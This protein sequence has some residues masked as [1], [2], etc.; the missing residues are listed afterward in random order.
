M[1]WEDL[2][3]EQALLAM[4]FDGGN[5]PTLRLPIALVHGSDYGQVV[6]RA[7]ALIGVHD[8]MEFCAVELVKSTAEVNVWASLS[9][10]NGRRAFIDVLAQFHRGVISGYTSRTV[11]EMW[12]ST[13]GCD[14]FVDCRKGEFVDPGF[15]VR[16]RLPLERGH[17]PI[18]NMTVQ[19]LAGEGFSAEEDVMDNPTLWTGKSGFDVE[20]SPSWVLNQ[21]DSFGL[22][23]NEFLADKGFLWRAGLSSLVTW[24]DGVWWTAWADML[25]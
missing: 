4:V 22:A 18:G 1:K 13:L 14:A 20:C 16:T 3:P 2:A 15:L 24:N 6:S 17:E 12:E 7:G 11:E 5:T 9:D 19:I 10:G 8:P 23:L 21:P 25:M